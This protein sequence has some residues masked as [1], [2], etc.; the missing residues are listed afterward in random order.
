MGPPSAGGIVLIQ[1]LNILEKYNFS[2]EEWGS[3]SYIH[4]LVEAMKYADADR[5]KHMGDPDFYKVPV[6][7]LISK[8]YALK[9]FNQI[10]EDAVPSELIFPSNTFSFNESEETTHY[11]VDD[12]FGHAVSSSITINSGLGSKV[13]V[14]GAGSLLNNQMDDF[15]IQPGVPNQFGLTGGE[16]N[17]I[18]PYKRM[19][20]AMTPTII[21]KNNKPYLVVGS[22]G[23]STIMTVVLQ[24]ILNV[25]DFNM[26]IQRANDVPRIH[27]QWLP[28]RIEY[29]PFGL[30]EDTKNNLKARGH[31]LGAER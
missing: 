4:K 11:S 17:K 15:S 7:K 30:P 10:T 27:H 6:D 25:I 19:V 26:N 5:S 20:S 2:R 3:I 13:V 23:G 22:P 8:D 12:K 14:D 16:A 1:V 24:V 28:D 18:E 9:I 29:E 31:I 21:L